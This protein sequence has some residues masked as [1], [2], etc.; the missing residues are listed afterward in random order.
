MHFPNETP[1]N[2]VLVYIRTAT[3]EPNFPGIPIYVDPIGL[4]V[5]E[6]TL[7]STVQM[8]FDAIPAR[9]A[10][11]L[12][13]KQLG[14]GYT[15]RSGFNMITDE[16]L[17]T[18]PVYD[19]REAR[20]AATRPGGRGEEQQ[21]RC[22]WLDRRLDLGRA[23]VGAGLRRLLGPLT[24]FTPALRMEAWPIPPVPRSSRRRSSTS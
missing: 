7:D 16:E 20:Q 3:S 9:D 5:A 19:L 14:L 10:L 21:Q 4:Q 1:L 18:I 2:D 15:L 13:L 12:I 6:R 11:R 24:H 23:G 17:S 8:E 22:I